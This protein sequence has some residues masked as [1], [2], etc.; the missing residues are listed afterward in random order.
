MR[1]REFRNGQEW[2]SLGYLGSVIVIL[3]VL[4]SLQAMLGISKANFIFIF[5]NFYCLKRNMLVLK[6]YSW[7][8]GFLWSLSPSSTG[9]I[10][11]FYGSDKD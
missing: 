5:R 2:K 11:T 7:I 3:H 9:A 10:Q 4:N 6:H 8:V 1:E